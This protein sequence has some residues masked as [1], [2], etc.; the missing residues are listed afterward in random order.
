MRCNLSSL[1][2]LVLS[3]AGVLFAHFIIYKEKFLVLFVNSKLPIE[4]S[5]PVVLPSS[6]LPSKVIYMDK[7]PINRNG[8][9][10]RAKLMGILEEHCSKLK[11][12]SSLTTF[13]GKFGIVEESDFYHSFVD[14]GNYL[15]STRVSRSFMFHKVSG[16]RSLEAA[17]IAL[18]LGSAD[19]LHDILNPNLTIQEVLLKYASKSQ[20]NEPEGLQLLGQHTEAVNVP[21][22]TS[23]QSDILWA[24]DTGKCIDGTPLL[25]R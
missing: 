1:S 2:R 15:I 20:D 18:H 5:L 19:A 24:Y 23:H 13:L 7:V 6:F 22:T 9:I 25:T 8:K 10:D 12:T 21:I 16:V 3:I 11:T 14:Y 17:E 4:D